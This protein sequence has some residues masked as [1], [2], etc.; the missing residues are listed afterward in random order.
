MN[1]RLLLLILLCFNQ[2][3][4]AVNVLVSIKPVHSLVSAI[5]QG[6]NKPALLLSDN[7]SAHSFA[8]KPSQARKISQADIIIWVGPSMEAPLNE[9]LAKQKGKQFIQLIDIP[10]LS[11]PSTHAEHHHGSDQ[12]DP[13]IWLSIQNAIVMVNYIQ[14]Q[15]SISDPSHSQ[16]YADNATQLIQHL[17]QLDSEL[18]AATQTVQDIPYMVFHNAYSHFEQAYHLN[19]VGSITL[20]GEYRRGARFISQL[21]KTI[22]EKQVQCLFEEPQFNSRISQMLVSG[23]NIRLGILDPLGSTITAGPEHYFTLMHLLSRSLKQCLS[24]D[25]Q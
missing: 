12:R 21:K 18:L 1:L 16:N 2:P 5:M 4:F 9:L 14:Q 23:T 15:L 11:F 20:N 6:V 24:G 13:H 7:Q 10:G 3:A 19:D 17:E 25:E 8:L 22:E